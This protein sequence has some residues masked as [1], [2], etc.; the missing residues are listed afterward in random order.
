MA[1]TIEE[2]RKAKR[3]YM[4]RKRAEDP[5]AARDYRNAYH[6]R[7]RGTQTAKMRDYYAKRFFW[8]RAA[9]LRG[10]GRA[11]SKDLAALWKSQRGRCAMTGRR[12]TRENAH[13]DHIV[14][15]ARGGSDRPEN[16]RWVCAQANLAKRD[17]SDAEFLA[18]CKDTMRWIGRRIQIVE[19][20]MS[21]L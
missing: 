7:N 9:K 2:T 21:V 8:G 10:S 20:L 11:T 12:L 4:A 14:A 3:E 19:D 6:A 15:K 1:R 17:M 16:L 5:Q 18:L 13:V